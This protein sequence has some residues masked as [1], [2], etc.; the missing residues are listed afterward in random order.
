[1]KRF[2]DLSVMMCFTVAAGLTLGA[3]SM[4]APASATEEAELIALGEFLAGECTTCHRIDGSHNG[5]PG[6]VGWHPDDFV[7]TLGFYARGDRTNPAMVSVAQSL[8][9]E[10]KRALALYFASLKPKQ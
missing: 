8:D 5:I 9:D 1:M 4:A 10:Q 2:G 7:E 3:A 6:I